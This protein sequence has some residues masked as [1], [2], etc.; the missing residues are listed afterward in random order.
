MFK[1]LYKTFIF[2][3]LYYLKQYSLFEQNSNDEFHYIEFKTE[4][5]LLYQNKTMIF[6]EK[7]ILIHNRLKITWA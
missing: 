1:A 4:F 6:L 3:N 5:D 2:N 7:Q